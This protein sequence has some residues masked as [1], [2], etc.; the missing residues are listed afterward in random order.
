MHDAKQ[1][2]ARF[3]LRLPHDVK[4]ALA[5]RARREERSLN[6]IIVRTLRESADRDGRG[7]AAA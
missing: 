2:L 3:E 4:A 1:S 6:Q 5:D 7:A